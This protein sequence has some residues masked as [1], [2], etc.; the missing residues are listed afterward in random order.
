MYFVLLG[1]VLMLLKV[2]DVADVGTWSWWAVLWPFGAAVAWWAYADKSGLTKRREMNRM[3]ERK[4]NRRRKQMQA[5]GMNPRERERLDRA[6]RPV[7]SSRFEQEQ[8]QRQEKNKE[9]IA[10]SS[11]FDSSQQSSHFDQR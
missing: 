8:A 6:K 4:Q 1:V 2:L 10:R 9:T 5:L 7:K 3:E 11:R